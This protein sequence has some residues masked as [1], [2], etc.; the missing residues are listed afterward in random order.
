M[1]LPYLLSYSNFLEQ[2]DDDIFGDVQLTNW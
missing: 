2:Q 1:S